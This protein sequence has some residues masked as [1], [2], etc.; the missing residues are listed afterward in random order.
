MNI[1]VY[2]GASE[3]KD[4]IYRQEIEK[5]GRVIG[6]NGHTLI[7]GG[8]K[9]GLMGAVAIAT[10][11]AGGRAIGVEPEFFINS[12]LQLDGLTELIV[13]KD[14]QER[15]AKMIELGDLFIAFPGGTGTFDEIAEVICLG[16]IGRLDKRYGYLNLNGYY[17]SIKAQYDKAVEEGF[18]TKKKRE[19]IMFFS[20]VEELAKYLEGNS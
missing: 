12:E 6:E 16:S 10:M 1:T 20:S 9:V 4:P 3:G 7:Y 18:I 14:M 17:D 8:S 15:K 13:T 5:L 19:K 2:L 11:K